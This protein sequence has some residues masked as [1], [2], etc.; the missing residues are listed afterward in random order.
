MGGALGGRR[1][2]PVRPDRARPEVFS[3]DT[4]PPTVSGSLHVGHVFSYTHTD[5]VARYRRMP[6]RRGVLPDG[7]GRQ[8]A[9]H[10]TPGPEL[11]RG[12]LRPVAALPGRLR[13]S[14]PA[15]RPAAAGEPAQFHRAVPPPHRRR[16]GRLR[17][18]VAAARAIG[19]LEP[20]LR[21]HRRSVTAGRSS[22]PSSA[23]WRGARPTSRMHRCCGTSTSGPPS[24]RP[25]WR[26]GS[27][28]GGAPHPVRRRL[29]IGRGRHHTTRAGGVVCR[30]GAPSRRRARLPA[31]RE[32]GADPGVRCGGAD[33]G[34]PPRRAR[35]GNRGRHGVHLRRHHRR[36]VVA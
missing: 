1:R 20:R 34:P 28:R 30:P 35:A 2:V 12:P 18:A 6:R 7:V 24:P 13:R 36:G 3:I 29:R 17:G 27:G 23:T 25:S 8:R 19:R 10:R 21:H 32:H 31:G 5:I 16:R 11:L 22:A 26:T 9:S 15:L 33:H 14:R 4:P